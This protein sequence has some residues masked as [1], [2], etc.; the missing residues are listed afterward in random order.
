VI[1]IANPTG[2]DLDRLGPARDFLEESV[3]R[4]HLLRVIP[5]LRDGALR[6]LDYRAE[7]LDV[8][9][10]SVSLQG[11]VLVRDAVTG[12]AEVR[13]VR[14]GTDAGGRLVVR[15]SPDDPEL[16][17]LAELLGAG[18][19]ERIAAAVAEGSLAGAPTAR[20]VAHRFGRRAA[21]R[22]TL[23]GPGGAPGQPR[24]L[25]VKVYAGARGEGVAAVLAW[26]AGRTDAIPATV[27]RLRHRDESR[28]LLA[29]DWLPGE[30]AHD[31]LLRGGAVETDAIGRAVR[32]L[33]MAAPPLPHYGV[34]EEL[35]TIR[36][37]VARV[38]MVRPGL[39]RRLE[40]AARAAADR[41]TNGD[42]A[43]RRL[44]HRDLHDKQVVCMSNGPGLIDWDLAA[45]SPR[46][47]DP[48]NFIAHLRLRA[49]QRRL[50]PR[51]AAG[52]R[53]AFLEGYGNGAGSAPPSEIELWERLTL[54][55]LAAVYGLRP[56]W[57]GLPSRLLA[58][59]SFG[60]EA[61]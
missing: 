46:A 32:G 54:L 58:A 22:L 27:P 11:L 26:L 51:Q 42:G 7:R 24:D 60:E 34:A 41:A 52:E 5:D 40:S 30:C 3:A 43:P 4:A 18:G 12:A 39:G 28:G 31:R 13:S 8:H 48:G 23:P 10:E 21:L 1:G 19:A 20:L 49:L 59:S 29:V 61:V 38:R 2:W 15:L 17:V 57:N 33:Q 56:G 14:F 50:S 47:L 6:L 44:A 37:F 45:D 55:R 53:R 36:K 16:P 9:G 35:A 25:L